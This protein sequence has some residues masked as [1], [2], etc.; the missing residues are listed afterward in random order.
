VRWRVAGALLLGLLFGAATQAG[1]R[2]SKPVI[3]LRIGDDFVVAQTDL[4]CEAQVGTKVIKGQKLVAC[5]KLKGGNLAPHSYVVAL[6]VNGRVVV[7]S[8]TNKG[9]IGAA[10]FNRTPSAVGAGEKQIL[11]RVGDRLLLAGT[12]L[13]CAVNNDSAGI[14]P[15]CF[16]VNAKGGLPG[17]YGFAETERFVAVLQFDNAGKK[18]KLIFKRNQGH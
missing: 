8:V 7:G 12:D 1:A 10:V 16:R 18:T 17:S 11:A 15:A 14:Y 6:G 5:F 9:S 13:A 4:A 2:P 3:T